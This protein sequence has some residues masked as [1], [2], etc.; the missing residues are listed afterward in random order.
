MVPMG[1]NTDEWIADVAS[2][3]RLGFGNAGTIVKPS[4][5][6]LVRKVGDRKTPWTLTELEPTLPSRIEDTPGWKLTASHNT[7]AAAN[8]VTGGGRWDTGAPQQAGSVYRS[9]CQRRRRSA[10][11]RSIRRC[12]FRSEAVAADEARS[13]TRRALPPTGAADSAPPH[14]PPDH[15]LHGAV[16]DR[17]RQRRPMRRK[18]T[19]RRQ[20]P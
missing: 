8:P 2:F 4:E 5:V 9:S 7:E 19:A 12:R 1:A 3:V 18:A 15:K 6:A 13:W 17:R 11:C 14:R 16:C 20:R 10:K